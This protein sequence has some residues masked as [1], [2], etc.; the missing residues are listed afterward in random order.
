MPFDVGV[1]VSDESY[2]TV[3][4]EIWHY[5]KLKN[6]SN[7]KF[8]FANP[9]LVLNDY[10]LI[11]SDAIGELSNP[12]W[13]SKLSRQTDVFQ[14]ENTKWDQGKAGDLYKNPH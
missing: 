1:G 4:Y 13:R 10:A 3:P 7:R 2:G 11:H 6:Q 8:V 9:D 12:N 5:Y 14:E